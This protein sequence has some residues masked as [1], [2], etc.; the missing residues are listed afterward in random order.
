MEGRQIMFKRF[1]LP[2]ILFITVNIL[3]GC[4]SFKE[5]GKGIAGISTKVLEENRESALKKSFALSYNDSYQKVK[6][7]LSKGALD[8]KKLEIPGSTPVIYADDRDKKMI[9]IY[10]SSLDTTPV[11]IFFTEKEA[12]TLVE[13]SS[14]STYAKEE[15]AKRIFSRLDSTKKTTTLGE[16]VNVEKEPDNK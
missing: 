11:G 4:A 15:I 3:S 7:I 14:P 2:V 16:T 9:A 12:E 10:L 13:V 1:I 6:D 5:I 8:E